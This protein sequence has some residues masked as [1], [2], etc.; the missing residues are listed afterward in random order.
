V[1][2]SLEF[3]ELERVYDLLAQAIDRVGEDGEVLFLSKLC[4][5]LAHRLGDLEAVE[6]AIQVA[7]E[8]P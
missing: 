1:N 4:I 8:S 3:A 7:L 5:T 2:H 6:E